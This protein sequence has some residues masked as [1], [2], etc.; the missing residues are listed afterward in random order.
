MRKTEVVGFFG[1]LLVFVLLLTFIRNSNT[2]LVGFSILNNTLKDTQD[3]KVEFDKYEREGTKFKFMYKIISLSKNHQDI[4][5]FYI[6]KDSD[7]LSLHEGEEKFFLKS[8]SEEE[9]QVFFDLPKNA[10]GKFELFM[11]FYNEKNIVELKQDVVL[12]SQGVSAFA[13]SESNKRTLSRTALVF[14]TLLLFYFT[15]RFLKGHHER[16]GKDKKIDRIEIEFK[17]KSF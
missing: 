7:G 11:N 13:V 9:K 12:S 17:D 1:L 14:I 15:V 6:L 3:F 5:L 10:F 8:E 2:D 4:S 16:T